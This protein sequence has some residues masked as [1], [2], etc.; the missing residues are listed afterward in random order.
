M[1]LPYVSVPGEEASHHIFLFCS[2]HSEGPPPKQAGDGQAPGA[3]QGWIQ[4]FALEAPSGEDS[5]ARSGS[6]ELL[7]SGRQWGK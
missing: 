4:L 6:T 2:T 5:V 3:P 1:C 7:H